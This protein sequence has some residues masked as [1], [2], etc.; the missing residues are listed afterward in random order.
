MFFYTSKS[1]PMETSLPGMCSFCESIRPMQF[2]SSSYM[3]QTLHLR[4]FSKNKQ[5]N[6]NKQKKKF[7]LDFSSQLGHF[8]IC[9]SGEGYMPL[10]ERL[11]HFIDLLC[12][13]YQTTNIRTKLYPFIFIFLEHS[14]ELGT[15]QA[16]DICFLNE[17]KE[18]LF[19][20]RCFLTRRSQ[21][22]N[23]FWKRKARKYN[24]VRY[25]KERIVI[26][27]KELMGDHNNGN[28]P[29]YSERKDRITDTM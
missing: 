20:F 29:T 3:D 15:Q 22:G 9:A 8:C 2:F 26:N 5:K 1:Q 16:L 17:V 11:L 28:P 12:I 27:F 7:F 4:S 10:L 13:S 24:N 21:R 18:S 14:T 25:E 6:R 19:D 23:M